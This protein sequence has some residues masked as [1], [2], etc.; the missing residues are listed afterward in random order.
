MSTAITRSHAAHRRSTVE[1]SPR[2]YTL[3]I[4][5]RKGLKRVELTRKQAQALA[6]RL[7][8]ALARSRP[9]PLELDQDRWLDPQIM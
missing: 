5:D 8:H 3:Y 6:D 4:R 9:E 1:T 2:G 7:Q